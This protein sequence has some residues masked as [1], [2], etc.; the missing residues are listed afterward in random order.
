MSSNPHMSDVTPEPAPT[1]LELAESL[2]PDYALGRAVE[3]VARSATKHGVVKLR[4]LATAVGYLQR[5]LEAEARRLGV[6]ISY[7][8][9]RPSFV[10]KEETR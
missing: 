3:Y 9:G 6:S 2:V 1:H 4:T 8:D 10:E 5:H 7:R